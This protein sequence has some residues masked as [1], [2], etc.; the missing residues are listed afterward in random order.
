[1]V[2]VESTLFILYIYD[3]LLSQSITMIWRWTSGTFRAFCKKSYNFL[4]NSL[5]IQRSKNIVGATVHCPAEAAQ[6]GGQSFFTHVPALTSLI[7]CGSRPLTSAWPARSGRRL[8]GPVRWST[9]CCCGS[10]TVLGRDT[11][12]SLRVFEQGPEVEVL[13]GN[14]PS[15]HSGTAQVCCCVSD[16]C[17]LCPRCSAAA[18]GRCATA[19]VWCGRLA[20]WEPTAGRPHRGSRSVFS[21]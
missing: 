11:S 3:W 1:M 16:T 12:R 8:P 15:Y 7:L 6:P 4:Y 18:L 19:Q 17:N 20:P 14:R 13:G 5:K 10:L 9:L 2:P 21:L